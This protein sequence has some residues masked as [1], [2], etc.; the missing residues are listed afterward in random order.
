MSV[1][2]HLSS[3]KSVNNVWYVEIHT[4]TASQAS[5]T[6]SPVL[7]AELVFK[8][9]RHANKNWSTCNTQTTNHKRTAENCHRYGNVEF[10]IYPL[11]L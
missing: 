5:L 10:I 3:P 11:S 9:S 8:T 4:T 2:L 7:E 6:L 1:N